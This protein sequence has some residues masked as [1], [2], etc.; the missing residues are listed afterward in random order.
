MKYCNQC[1]ND[2]P[3][4]EFNKNRSRVD[5]HADWCRACMAGWRKVWKWNNIETYRKAKKRWHRNLSSA[6]K[7]RHNE[8]RRQ[9]KEANPGMAKAHRTLNQAVLSGEI[10]KPKYCEWCARNRKLDATHSNYS[11]PLDVEW[12]C[13]PCHCVKDGKVSKEGLK[14]QGYV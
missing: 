7:D 4:S 6:T 8:Q 1:G 5:G 12:L 3:L 13:R 2:K 14:A 9:Y 10:V 11:K